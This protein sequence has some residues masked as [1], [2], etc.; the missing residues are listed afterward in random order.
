MLYICENCG[1]EHEGV[2]ASGRFCSPSCSRSFASKNKRKEINLKVS[3]TLK[4]KKKLIVCKE[5]GKQ[6]EVY[7]SYSLGVCEECRYKKHK[8]K[9]CGALFKKNEKGQYVSNC[10]R[11][12]VCSKQRVFKS[13]IKYFGF[14]K[15]VIGTSK[16][17]EE[18]DRVKEEI[19]RVYWDE[20]LSLPALAERY[21]YPLKNIW[22]F[23]KILHSLDIELRT[24]SEGQYTSLKTGRWKLP[25][26][27]NNF[28]SEWHVS[29]EGKRFF[30]RSS[31]ES[32]FA[33]YLDEKK[34]KYECESLRISYFDS[35][36]KRNRIAVPDFYLPE[37]NEIVEIKSSWTFDKQNMKDKFMAY[38]KLGYSPKV[39]L[40]KNIELTKI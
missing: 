11:P 15:T 32:E 4:K 14:D 7:V 25:T 19:K 28:K 17:I 16:V 8:C 3:Q 5:C 23:N 33:K 1:K 9:V 24:V 29:W 12:D 2:Y 34:I 18:F 21:H 20:E 39:I 30:L 40:N 35:M 22:N 26:S 31:Y 27:K 38:K 36:K 6:S 13:L 37:T 10:L